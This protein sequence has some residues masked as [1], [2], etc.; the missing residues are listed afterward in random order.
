MHE[1]DRFAAS[2]GRTL[3]LLDTRANDAGEKLYASVGWTK[4]GAVPCYA[5]SPDGSM[6]GTTFWYKTL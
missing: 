1:V 6:E 5:Y 3:L 4:F 2:I